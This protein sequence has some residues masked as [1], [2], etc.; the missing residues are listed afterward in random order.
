LNK[1]DKAEIGTII[2]P[3][4]AVMISASTGYGLE[5]LKSAVSERIAA[6][7]HPIELLVPYD[8]GNVL[9]MLHSQGQVESEE[10][11]DTGVKVV[12]LLDATLYARV[13][14]MLEK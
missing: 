6:M 9:S 2:E 7:R 13:S 14:K 12:C 10:Y 1:C 3:A 5:H 11:L 4:D 8:K